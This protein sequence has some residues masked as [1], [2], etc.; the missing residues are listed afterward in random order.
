MDPERPTETYSSLIEFKK[1]DSNG[2]EVIDLNRMAAL[3]QLLSRLSG[4]PPATYSQ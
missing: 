1:I 4:F 3:Y 2:T